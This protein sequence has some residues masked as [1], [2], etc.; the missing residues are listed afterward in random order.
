MALLIRRR[1]KRARQR[2]MAPLREV[3][4]QI[5]DLL[6]TSRKKATLFTSAPLPELGPLATAQDPVLAKPDARG[7]TSSPLLGEFPPPAP[8]LHL[9]LNQSAW[10]PVRAQIWAQ[11][12][13]R[14]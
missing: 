11:S 14:G 12:C 13:I 4:E 2:P 5:A 6:S 7:S 3:I 8:N 10:R 1:G 9:G